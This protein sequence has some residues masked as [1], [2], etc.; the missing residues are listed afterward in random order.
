MI[1][2]KIKLYMQFIYYIL[3][4]KY[5]KKLS[6]NKRLYYAFHGGF[7]VGQYYLFDLEHNDLREYLSEYDWFK[8]RMLNKPY[9]YIVNNKFLLNEYLK[10]YIRTPKIIAVK[11]KGKIAVNSHSNDCVDNLIEVIKQNHKVIIKPI[12]AGKGNHV[13]I[14]EIN[15]QN[16]VYVDD[17]LKEKKE[18]KNLLKKNDN[19]L[20]SEVVTQHEY[21]GNI[22]NGSVNTIRIIVL[23]KYGD[24]KQSKIVYAVHRFG[25]SATG[26]VDNA[27]QGGIISKIDIDTGILSE[28]RSIKN[29]NVYYRHP[30]TKKP[31]EGVKIPNWDQIK[32]QVLYVSEQLFFLKII[33]WDV[34]LTEKGVTVIE[35]NSSSGVNILQL[36]DGQRNLELGKFLRK[37]NIIK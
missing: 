35:A 16:E 28:A 26:V 8:S 32:E 23:N 31:I 7:T 18:L 4:A 11:Q 2:D 36:W 34:V 37:H 1:K 3:L 9:D 25:T 14:I 19:W 12:L 30:D 13:H 5:E 6:I 15:Q 10:P 21:A 24:E 29:T 17:K 33:A 20:L 27:S 22:Y